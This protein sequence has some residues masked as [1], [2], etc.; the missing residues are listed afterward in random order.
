[1]E[2]VKSPMFFLFSRSFYTIKIISGWEGAF[3]GLFTDLSVLLPE[4]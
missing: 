4:S 2:L 1:M 3:Y